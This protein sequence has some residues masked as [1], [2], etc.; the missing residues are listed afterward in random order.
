MTFGDGTISVLVAPYR[1]TAQLSSR[2]GRIVVSEPTLNG[3]GADFVDTNDIR[4]RTQA[5]LDQT[6]NGPA[7]GHGLH[8]TNVTVTHDGIRISTG[9]VTP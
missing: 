2:D 4:T 6:L 7:A 1:A 9:P 5:Y 3:P 8:I